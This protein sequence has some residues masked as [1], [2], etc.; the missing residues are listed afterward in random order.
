M[1]PTTQVENYFDQIPHLPPRSAGFEHV[2][3]IVLVGPHP[4]EIRS[5]SAADD[6]NDPKSA[7]HEPV[8]YHEETQVMA[9]LDGLV[10]AGPSGV[11]TQCDSI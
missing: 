3:S 2:T 5:I 9:Q 11:P 1:D 6:G 10:G 4:G 8:Y 7:T